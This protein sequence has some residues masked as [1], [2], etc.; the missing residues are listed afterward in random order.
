MYLNDNIIGHK[1]Q[2]H[3]EKQK[4][5]KTVQMVIDGHNGHCE[6]ELANERDPHE[7]GRWQF[8]FMVEISFEDQFNLGYFRDT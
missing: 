4:Q 8:M 2:S 1:G 6:W 3:N 5:K 7:I